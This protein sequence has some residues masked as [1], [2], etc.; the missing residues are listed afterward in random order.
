MSRSISSY[1]KSMQ[2]TVISRRLNGS[3]RGA[4]YWAAMDAKNR[5]SRAATPAEVS[6]YREQVEEAAE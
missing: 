6:E 1:P 5:S 2:P 3:L 4:G